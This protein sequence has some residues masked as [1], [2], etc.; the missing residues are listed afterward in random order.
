MGEWEEDSQG[1]SGL[2]SHPSW[3]SEKCGVIHVFGAKRKLELFSATVVFKLF[4][5][6]STVYLNAAE[7]GRL[8]GA[9]CRMLKMLCGFQHPMVLH[10][11]NEAI[12]QRTCQVPFTERPLYHQLLMY[13]KV[14]R[15][16]AGDPLRDSVFTP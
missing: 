10:V 13:G 2:P 4:N 7:R 11:S 9:H 12:R 16:Q 8:D 3:I 5:S 15:G 1:V 14:A 6:L